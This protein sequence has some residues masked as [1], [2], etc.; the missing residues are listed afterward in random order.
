MRKFI[1]ISY[2][3]GF[4]FGLYFIDIFLNLSFYVENIHSEVLEYSSIKI[5]KFEILVF[6][7]FFMFSWE[8]FL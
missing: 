7:L 2:G 1:V 5:S 4:L 8:S 3:I 6:S